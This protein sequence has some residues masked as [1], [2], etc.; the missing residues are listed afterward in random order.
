VGLAGKKAAE[1]DAHAEDFVDDEWIQTYSGH[2]VHPLKMTVGDIRI[3]DI[4]HS[5]SNMCRFL[6]HCQKFYS[7]AQHCC[8]VAEQLPGPLKIYGLLHDASEA[9]IIDVPKL[10]KPRVLFADKDG[11]TLRYEEVELFIQRVV[12]E[13]FDLSEPTPQDVIEIKNADKLMLSVEV[14][15]LIGQLSRQWKYHV[16]YIVGSGRLSEINPW[17]PELAK[18]NFLSAF[19]R[20]M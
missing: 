1:I 9:Y 10:I 14:R 15:D 8:H 4:A 3:E 19:E 17:P 18:Q 13:A 2:A 12:W 7:V 20:Y 5:L 11:N 16:G 6:G